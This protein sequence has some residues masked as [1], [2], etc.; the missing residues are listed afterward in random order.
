MKN[1]K[2]GN[3]ADC[4]QFNNKARIPAEN[5][6]WAQQ[7]ECDKLLCIHLENTENLSK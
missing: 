4:Y 5:E 2:S 6:Q 1:N 7:C 3:Q